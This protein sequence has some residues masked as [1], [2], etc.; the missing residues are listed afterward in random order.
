MKVV[1]IYAL[2]HVFIDF[3]LFNLGFTTLLF[4]TSTHILVD[5][6]QLSSYLLCINKPSFIK[7]TKSVK[8]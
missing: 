2:D 7:K 8:Q 4:S 5:S 1:F 6:R 3:F